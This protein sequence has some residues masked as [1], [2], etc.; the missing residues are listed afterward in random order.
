[1]S[2]LNVDT[3]KKADGTGN[4]SVPAETGTVVTTASPSLGRRNRIINGNAAIDQRN[5]GSSI[6]PT[7]GQYSVDR[8]ICLQSVSSKYSIQQNAGSVTPPSGFVNYAGVTSLS[9]YSVASGDQ[10]YVAQR[11]E[12]NNLS[13]LG[14]GTSGAQSV[15]LSFWVRSSLTGVFGGSVV[16][17]PTFNYSYPFSYT[18]SSAN[19]WEYKTVTI[20]GPVSGTWATSGNGNGLQLAFGLG[21]GSSFSG[22][23][24]AWASALY[25][26]PTGAT[27]VV[28]TSGATFY[29]TGV[30]LEVGSVATP[31]EH[32][33]YGEELAAC[34]R[35]Y[36]K[37]IDGS[38]G[39]F[40]GIGAYLT[41]TR[42]DMSIQ[43]PVT[44]R[45]SPSIVQT[46]NTNG[47]YTYDGAQD[48]FNG[49]D[50]V[51]SNTTKGTYIYVTSNVS[52]SAG[53]GS[54]VSVVN[55]GASSAKVAFNAE[56]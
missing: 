40:A 30:Q 2:Q 48:T 32:R 42:F 1:V 52:G 16:N 37:H 51:T 17:A 3:I 47:Y 44:M 45:T 41:S 26:A 36:Y 11:I 20:E 27:S 13:D 10:F 24:N 4:L 54:T 6:T 35:Y 14:W 12:A 46:T 56:L 23:A 18:I 34:Q 33:S 7:N 49:W 29:I 22:T 31:F 43:F 39:G 8:F 19:T 5:G 50:G 15:T 53:Q 28:G 25:Y 21:V 9:A 38:E 55:S